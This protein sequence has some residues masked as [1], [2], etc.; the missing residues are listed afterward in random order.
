M[1]ITYNY[2]FAKCHHSVSE[3]QNCRC[4]RLGQPCEQFEESLPGPNGFCPACVLLPDP[5]QSP[6]YDN[7]ASGPYQY[8]LLFDDHLRFGATQ[9]IEAEDLLTQFRLRGPEAWLLDAHQVMS[10][11]DLVCLEYFIW[12]LMSNQWLK[13]NSSRLYVRGER[14]LIVR[15][16]AI[17]RFNKQIRAMQQH[18]EWRLMY[19]E[20]NSPVEAYPEWPTLLLSCTPLTSA[21]ISALEDTERRCMVCL[22]SFDSFDEQAI[23]TPCSHIMGLS[24]LKTWFQ[25]ANN[26]NSKKCPYCR[27]ALVPESNALVEHEE[28]LES[29]EEDLLEIIERQEFCPT[30]E[31]LNFLALLVRT[32]FLRR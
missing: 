26:R 6:D 3:I 16:E 27:Q 32:N 30:P 7:N 22:E 17:L 13:I 11:E 29:L 25:N 14:E 20:L 31:W 8:A 12:L 21:E 24:C 2:F 23:Y 15:L 28:I 1:C 9:Q 4:H 18:T 5:R 10:S 19:E